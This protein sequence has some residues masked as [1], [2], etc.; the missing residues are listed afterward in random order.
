MSQLDYDKALVKEFSI[1][2]KHEPED[3]FKLAHARTQ[4][5]EIKKFLWRERVELLLS[6]A[7]TKSEVEALAASA[8]SKVAEHRSNIKNILLSIEVLDELVAELEAEVE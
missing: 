5:D 3:M 4:L 6:E 8:K 2:E 1:K 7:Q